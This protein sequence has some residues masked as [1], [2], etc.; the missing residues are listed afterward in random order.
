MTNIK[1]CPNC[2][3]ENHVEAKNCQCG[4]EFF[5]KEVVDEMA[6]TNTTVI[7]DPVPEFVWKLIGIVCPIA[8]I[9]LGCLWKTK[10]PERKKILFKFSI[11]MLIFLGVVVALTIFVVIGKA[12]GDIV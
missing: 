12:T 2:Q 1:Y 11:G 3:K 7:A 9:I 4:Y 5:I 10:W 6:S 8:G